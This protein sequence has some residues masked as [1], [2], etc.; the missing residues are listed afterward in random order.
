MPNLA[1]PASDQHR[2]LL[3]TFDDPAAQAMAMA[4]RSMP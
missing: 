4:V 1:A 3:T 2:R